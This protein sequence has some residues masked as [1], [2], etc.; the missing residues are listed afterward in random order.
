MITLE[1]DEKEFHVTIPREVVN[2]RRL[3]TFVQWLR[4]ESAAHDAMRSGRPA[5]SLAEIAA[6]S[7][8]TATEADQLAAELTAGWWARNRQRFLPSEETGV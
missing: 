6:T 1:S 8:M 2:E 7:Q 5:R 4:D 3:E